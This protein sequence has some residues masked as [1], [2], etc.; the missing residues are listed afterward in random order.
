MYTKLYISC[1]RLWEVYGGIEG[2]TCVSKNKT[3]EYMLCKNLNIRPCTDRTV[4]CSFPPE[5]KNF[6]M[7]DITVN[8][9][10]SKY[11]KGNGKI[12]FSVFCNMKYFYVVFVDNKN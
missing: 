1:Y 4:Y 12:M 8:P 3:D 11:E 6:A 5:P 10:G 7:K 9:E 2:L